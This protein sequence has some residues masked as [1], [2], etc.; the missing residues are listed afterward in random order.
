MFDDRNCEPWIGA[1]Y[2]NNET[3]VLVIG[4]SRYSDDHTDRDIIQWLLDGHR[5][6]TFTG[7]VQAATGA[8]HWEPHYDA[9]R[10]W[11]GALF[12]NYNQTAFPGGAREPLLWQERMHPT[13]ARL[14]REV[15]R[16]WKPT[17][18]IVWGFANWNSLVIEG[19]K[20]SEELL[21]PG[22]TEPYCTTSGFD[23]LFT[24]IYHPSVGFNHARWS[25]ML[26]AFLAMRAPVRTDVEASAARAA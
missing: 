7:F 4:E 14:L 21:I 3:R 8:R 23:T 24:R 19:E 20:W 17:H 26:K 18:A 10:F 1:Y 2:G 9:H 16:E 15:L 22:T 13:N 25:S 5:H 11:N 6:R 12:H